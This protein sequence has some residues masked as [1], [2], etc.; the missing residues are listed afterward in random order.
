VLRDG[1]LLRLAGGTL[2][3]N[4]ACSGIRSIGALLMLTALIG[5]VA[6]SR[7]WQRALLIALSVP[8]AIVLNGA[9]VALTGIAVTYFGSSAAAGATHELMGLAVFVASLVTVWLVHRGLA[10]AIGETGQL[11][12]T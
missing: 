6:E 9:R 3:V 4:E 11:R 7:T 5:Y 8:L 2:D 12:I 10:A 1:N